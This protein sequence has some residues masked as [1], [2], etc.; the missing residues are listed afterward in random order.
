MNLKDTGKAAARRKNRLTNAKKEMLIM[1]LPLIAFVVAM[2]FLT[3]SQSI[4]MQRLLERI[5]ALE[6]A[7]FS[8]GDAL[9]TSPTDL[10]TAEDEDADELQVNPIDKFFEG[11]V[12]SNDTSSNAD[13]SQLKAARADLWLAE[14]KNGYEILRKSIN[15]GLI[16]ERRQALLDD[17]NTAEKAFIDYADRAAYTNACAVGSSSFTP[18]GKAA[19]NSSGSGM[20]GYHLHLLGDHYRSEA[21]RLYDIAAEFTNATPLRS[22]LYLT[23]GIFSTL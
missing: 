5:D 13:M 18:Y 6:A 20:G 15:S 9:P 10:P 7:A 22:S 17:L 14:V 16:S 4:D 19:E 1:L 23:I 3:I 2:V 8:T 21:L 11:Y 12:L